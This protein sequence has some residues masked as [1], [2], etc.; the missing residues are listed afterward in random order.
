[1]QKLVSVEGHRWAIEDIFETAKNELGL[2]TKL[3]PSMA[4][5]AMSHS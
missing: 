5:I 3:A 1:M 4:G 2:H